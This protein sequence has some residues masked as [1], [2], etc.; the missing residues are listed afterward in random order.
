MAAARGT[1]EF[2]FAPYHTQLW[3]EDKTVELAEGLHE[4]TQAADRLGQD[5]FENWDNILR[6]ADI[7]PDNSGRRRS[8][9]QNVSVPAVDAGPPRLRSIPTNFQ[10]ICPR[11]IYLL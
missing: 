1:L 7:E 4:K 11:R 5:R 9:R 3:H 10:V 8:D 2:R 6:L